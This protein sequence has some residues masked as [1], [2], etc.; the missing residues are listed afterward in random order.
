V[1][2]A[3]MIGIMIWRPRGLVSTREPS[4]HLEEKKPIPAAIVEEARK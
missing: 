3:A 4:V 1:F 2:G